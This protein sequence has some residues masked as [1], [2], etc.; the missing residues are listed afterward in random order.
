LPLD[1][2]AIIEA[3][4]GGGGGGATVVEAEMGKVLNVERR[5]EETEG[6]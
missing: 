6:G 1:T 5:I 3:R 2:V 4:L